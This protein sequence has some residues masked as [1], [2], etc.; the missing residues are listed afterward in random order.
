MK[1]QS[2]PSI[3]DIELEI[4]RTRVRLA[5]TADALA[6]ELAPQ[7][8]ARN[9]VEMLN[10]FFGRPDAIKFG[11]M[12]ADPVALGLVGLGVA[13]LVAENL[14]I[15]DGIIPGLSEHPPSEHP[16]AAIETG[17]REPIKSSPISER[18][19]SGGWFHQAANATQG[20]FRSVYDSSGAVVGQAS[21][22]IAHQVGSGQKVSQAVGGNPWLLGLAG[23]AVGM[24]AAMLLPTSRPE[25]EIA[26]QAREEMWE[27]AEEIGNRAA[28]TVREMAED[29]KA[30]LA[31]DR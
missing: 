20:A 24:A 8:L 12:R 31:P 26:T 18:D 9:G 16:S 28:A 22:L 11:G 3:D 30:G 19:Q 15:L 29:L 17:T 7:H 27:T 14:G 1:S 6:D 21:K 5:E 2:D 13:W 25:R 23:L 4:A 10:E